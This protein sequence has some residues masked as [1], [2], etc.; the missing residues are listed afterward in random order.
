MA[1]A[2]APATCYDTVFQSL[3][4]HDGCATTVHDGNDGDELNDGEPMAV[5]NDEYDDAAASPTTGDNGTCPVI[6]PR[7]AAFDPRWKQ[8]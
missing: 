5:N 2:P 1:P 7:T 4:V 3:D 6:T 8:Y